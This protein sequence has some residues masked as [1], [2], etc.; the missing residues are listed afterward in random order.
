[1]FNP[2]ITLA[3]FLHHRISRQTMLGYIFVQ[4]V[5]A[6]FGAFA[7]NAVVD[8][9]VDVPDIQSGYEGRAF[10]VSFF[11]SAMLVWVYLM[12]HSHT[13]KHTLAYLHTPTTTS[14]WLWGS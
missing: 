8:G 2:A 7:A 11:Y 13:H 4:L 6:F 9:T 3:S 1:M 10:L 5:G 12:V 14:C